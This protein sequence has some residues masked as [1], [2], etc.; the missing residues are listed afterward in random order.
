MAARDQAAGHNDLEAV[1]H[2]GS[3]PGRVAAAAA[4]TTAAAAAAS[5][6]VAERVVQT[7]TRSSSSSAPLTLTLNPWTRSPTRLPVQTAEGAC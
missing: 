6:A 2:D 1:H 4:G 5:S 7:Q 3:Y